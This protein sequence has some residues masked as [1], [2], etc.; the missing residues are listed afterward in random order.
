MW[1]SRN[2]ATSPTAAATVSP[3]GRPATTTARHKHGKPK[4]GYSYL[5]TAL[6]DH[7]RLAYTEILPD[8]TKETAAAFW[9]RAHACNHH[10]A[11]TA[12]GGHPPASRVPNLSGQYIQGLFSK[13]VRTGRP[14]IWGVGGDGP[15]DRPLGEWP[16]GWRRAR[17]SFRAQ[18]GQ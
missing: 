16:A 17:R 3:T 18:C 2:S 10:R 9:H 12:L 6:D 11:H 7:S 1:T 14:V 4:I 15:S 5:H 13:G 8:G